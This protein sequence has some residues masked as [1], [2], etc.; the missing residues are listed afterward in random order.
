[1]QPSE[2]SKTKIEPSRIVCCD[3]LE[4]LAR[5]DDNSIHL[6]VTS[7]P[8]NVGIEYDKHTD[9]MPH[10]QYLSWMNQIW[11]ECYRILV[12]GGRICINIDATMNLEENGLPER[13]HPLHVDFTNQLR[14]IGY[15]YRGEICW[16]KQN[17][18][19]KD[20]AWG[21]YCLCSNPHIRRNSEYVILACK[22]S[23][24]LEGDP[25][26]CDLTKD[27]FHEWTLSEWKIQPETSN[28]G[29]PVPFPRELV[30]RCI[31][32][33]SYVGNVVL[34]PFNGSGTTTT[35]AIEL[36]RKWIG[37]DNSEKYCRIAQYSADQA[38]TELELAGGYK[39]K[40]APIHVKEAQQAK[41]H[42]EQL[43][44]FE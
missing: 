19:G 22:E 32:L 6:I 34:D 36:G 30:Y 11:C 33:F 21:S 1:M 43:D 2:L 44:L 16:T 5:I 17:A 4:G 29:H 42:Q 38:M 27:E 14:E 24:K 9:T 41:G 23:L 35:T 25:M 3:V 20:T 37:I 40:P 15:I 13:V 28:K 26:L 7:S 39:F 31:K 12:P 18:P 10:A 8:F